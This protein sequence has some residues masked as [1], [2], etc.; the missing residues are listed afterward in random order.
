MA[1][2]VALE[3]QQHELMNDTE[4]DSYLRQ[5]YPQLLPLASVCVKTSF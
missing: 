3:S 4:I 1:E 5:V 2:T